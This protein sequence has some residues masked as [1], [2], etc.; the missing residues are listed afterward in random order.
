MIQEEM[1][2]FHISLPFIPDGDDT[3]NPSTRLQKR[4]GGMLI[5]SA[6]I[7]DGDSTT[8]GIAR[9]GEPLMSI[10]FTGLVHDWA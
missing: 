6:L 10:P 9:C 4:V 3:L 2:L 8:Q 7:V 1:G 5:H